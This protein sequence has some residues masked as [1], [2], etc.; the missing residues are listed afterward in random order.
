MKHLVL[1]VIALLAIVILAPNVAAV[2]PELR[3]L[4]EEIDEAVLEHARLRVALWAPAPP[5]K[6]VALSELKIER[7][8][9]QSTAWASDQRHVAQPFPRFTVVLLLG[10]S[11]A[12][13]APTIKEA[14]LHTGSVAEA[15]AVIQDLRSGKVKALWM[16]RFEV[17]AFGPA[18]A[19]WWWEIRGLEY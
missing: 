11:P 17:Q 2:S 19:R 7:F 10:A 16:E 13:D 4:A 5:G 15:S 8:R 3:E 18:E 14:F 12:K 1:C 9:I 6:Y